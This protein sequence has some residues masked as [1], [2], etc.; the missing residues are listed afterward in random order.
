MAKIRYLRTD[1]HHYY[2]LIN[3]PAAPSQHAAVACQ[4]LKC[5][6]TVPAYSITMGK[7]QT[8]GAKSI[9]S[10]SEQKPTDGA[11]HQA[12]E[13]LSR[14]TS[15][16]VPAAGG[17]QPEAVKHQERLAPETGQRASGLRLLS[18]LSSS[19]DRDG[20]LH[21]RTPPTYILCRMWMIVEGEGSVPGSCERL[22][23]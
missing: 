17:V 22:Q 3:V 18:G 20:I 2:L 13:L 6:C 8:P 11:R 14:R 9:S 15:G 1:G 10:H 23:A 5:E 21:W 16:D 7:S 4:K 19:P 12:R